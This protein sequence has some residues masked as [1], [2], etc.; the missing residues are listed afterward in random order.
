M[1]RAVSPVVASVISASR[2][3]RRHLIEYWLRARALLFGDRIGYTLFLGSLV[4]FVCYWRVGVFITDS[5]TVLNTLVAVEQGRLHIETATYGGLGAPGTHLVDGRVYGRNYGQVFLALPFLLAFR[6][7]AAVVH[8]SVAVTAGWSLLLLALFRSFGELFERSRAGSVIGSLVA[9]AAFGI[10]VAMATPTAADRLPIL[11]L[12]FGTIVTTAF[13]TVFTYRLAT[14]RTTHQAGIAAGIAYAAVL[15]T[16]FWAS[17]PK[18]HALSVTLLIV[19]L[20]LLHRA[21]ETDLLSYR[22]AAYVPGGLVAWIHAPEGF[23]L[24]TSIG[25]ADVATAR[26]NTARSLTAVAGV[27][28][29]SLLPFFVT[30]YLVAGNPIQPPR[31]TPGF[32]GAALKA[33]ASVGT[34]TVTTP[35]GGGSAPEELRTLA[36]LGRFADGVDVLLVA[37]DRVIGTFVLSEGFRS[38]GRNMSVLESAPLLGALVGGVICLRRLSVSGTLFR[39]RAD[40]PKAAVGVAATVYAVLLVLLFLP[41]LPLQAQIT[42]RYLLPLYPLGLLLIVET[43]AVR[44]VLA[45]GWQTLGWSY[46]AGILLGSQ[47]LVAGVELAGATLDGAM[48]LESHLALGL[49]TLLA[50]WTLAYSLG[51]DSDGSLRAGAILL[52]LAAAAGTAFVLVSAFWYF[53]YGPFALPF[54]PQT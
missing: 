4:L 54:I 50:A 42:A 15:P 28:C 25:L 33:T 5:Y 31:L 9:L 19:S 36:F 41:S 20:Y 53:P 2:A 49:A 51:A 38:D 52:G 27:L 22:A 18:R 1:G 43:P 16:A 6:G 46:L 48:R 12:Q 39:L 23:L 37:P 44:A 8:T 3:S 34:R 21:R 45:E 17:I 30:N 10:G 7:L 24:V 29:L 35:T 47:L 14:A 26:T 40:R 13:G 32:D 11:A